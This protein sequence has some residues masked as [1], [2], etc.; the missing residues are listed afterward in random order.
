MTHSTNEK[1]HYD[2]KRRSVEKFV[3]EDSVEVEEHMEEEEFI[4]EP[5]QFTW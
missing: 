4:Y 3:H 1:S 2:E 5:R